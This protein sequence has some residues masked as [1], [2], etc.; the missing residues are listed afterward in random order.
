MSRELKNA[1]ARWHRLR[2][3]ILPDLIEREANRCAYCAIPLAWVH[4]KETVQPCGDAWKVRPGYRHGTVDHII[5]LSR[6][7]SNDLENLT[8]ACDRCNRR[9]GTKEL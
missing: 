6:G 7:G 2:H 5:P 8:L 9:K 4:M 3:K 1:R